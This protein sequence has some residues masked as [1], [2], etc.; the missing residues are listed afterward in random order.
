[1]SIN[2]IASKLDSS[3]SRDMLAD[4]VEQYLSDLEKERQEAEK[5]LK[6]DKSDIVATG[7][8]TAYQFAE[9]M[10]ISRL[11]TLYKDYS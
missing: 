3:V 9:E 11:S 6:A 4:I 5:T 10:L 1:M 2:T 8:V 7:I